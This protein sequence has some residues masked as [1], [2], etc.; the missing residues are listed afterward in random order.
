MGTFFYSF[1]SVSIVFILIA[2]LIILTLSI[3]RYNEK[4]RILKILDIESKINNSSIDELKSMYKELVEIYNKLSG[5][6]LTKE[7]VV[8]TKTAVLCKIHELELGIIS[9]NIK[10]P[11][12]RTISWSTEDFA[13]IAFEKKGESWRDFYDESMFEE[14]LNNMIKNHDP[15]YGI[16]WE[17][18]MICLDMYCAKIEKTN[19]IFLITKEKKR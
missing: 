9:Q 4:K 3:A 16:T 17:T 10:N 14:A 19:S 7:R 12:T 2:M 11:V 18:V 6:I 13:R 1:L 8:K 15:I 5:T